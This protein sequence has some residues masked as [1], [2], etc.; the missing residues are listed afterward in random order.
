MILLGKKSLLVLVTSPVLI[1]MVLT[2]VGGT[3]FAQEGEAEETPNRYGIAT[4]LGRSFDATGDLGFVMLT[5]FGLFDYGKV[6]HHEAPKELRFRVE[7]SI[8]SSVQPMPRF[9]TSLSMFAVY[10][11]DKYC[12]WKWLRPYGEAGIGVI[13]TDFQ[14][15]EQGSRVN[16]N[17]QAGIGTEILAGSGP[18]FFASLRFFHIS[19]AG[20][21]SE[22]RGINCLTLLLG[23]FF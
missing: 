19:N 14:L 7:Y 18:P 9:M 13:Y 1:F 2:I 21:A 16:F 5:G 3:T 4:T 17:P 23:R 20:L 22:N 10:Y 12:P 8:G 11:V 6:W 15:P